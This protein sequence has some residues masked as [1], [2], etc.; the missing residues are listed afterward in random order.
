MS[1]TRKSRRTRNENYTISAAAKLS[2]IEQQLRD[3]EI[4]TQQLTREKERIIKLQQEKSEAAKGRT[5]TRQRYTASRDRH[6]ELLHIGDRVR[7]LTA[8]RFNSSTGVVTAIKKYVSV[9][10]PRGIIITRK[11]T[12]LQKFE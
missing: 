11:S 1:N 8:G 6:G 3:L 2:Q 9:T 7:I 12:N 10:D 4:E 5:T